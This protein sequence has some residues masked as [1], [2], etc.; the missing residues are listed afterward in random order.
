MEKKPLVGQKMGIGKVHKL[1]MSAEGFQDH[2]TTDGS[3]LGVLGMW[4]ACG[5]SV[6]QRDHDEEMGPM[7]G[8][9]GMLGAESEVQ[10]TI[11]RAEL[12]ASCVSSGKL[13]VPR[14]VERKHEVHWPQSKGRRLVELDL[15]RTAQSSPR[16]KTG[17]G[18]EHVKAH[19]SKKE[20][21]QKSF[22]EKFITEGHE[23]AD[24]QAKDGAM[25]D[26]GLMA[27]V[28]TSAVQQAREEVYTALQYAAN[29]HCLVEEWQDCEELKTQAK[30]KVDLRG[31]ETG[32]QE[33][34]RVVVCGCKQR[35]L[36]EI[37]KRQQQKNM[38]G[39]C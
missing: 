19:R 25:M 39:T 10:R 20:K 31:Q 33:A 30:N 28:R 15:G 14:F 35:P 18:V 13:S 22:F 2:V 21:Q 24:E 38:P 17:R 26:G 5:W 7:H 27:Q 6:V 4:G 23:K 1:G 11:K 3:L 9:Y 8:M 37:R 34:S 16:R 12:T 29:F 32:S 36:H